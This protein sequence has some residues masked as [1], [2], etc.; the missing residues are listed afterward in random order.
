MS[1]AP[2]AAG[3]VVLLTRWHFPSMRVM[4]RQFWRI[5]TLDRA[6]RY[7]PGC[8][9]V[10]R[11]ASRRSLL[12]TSAWV[13]AEAAARWLASDRFAEFDRT[14]RAVPGVRADVDWLVER[15]PR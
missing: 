10:H 5:R 3:H 2:E 12:L 9:W 11:W 8:L 1:D 6:T 4:P 7:V 15:T 14:A 13:D